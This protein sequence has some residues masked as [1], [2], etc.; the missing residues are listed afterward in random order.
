MAVTNDIALITFV[1][2]TFI[3]L[4]LIGSEA[5]DRLLVP[6]VVLQTIAANLGSMLTPIGNPQNLYL[7]GKAGLSLGSFLLLMLPYALV[8]LL[9]IMLWSTVLTRKD[10]ASIA[11]SF[12]EEIQLLGQGPQLT[13][14]FLLFVLDLLTV[15]RIVPYGLTTIITVVY[16]I[17]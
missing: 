17:K 13:V 16:F 12:T 3:V 1:P 11:V 9:L 6:V 7:Y 5:R 4:R 2:F 8:S 14:Y 10:N 15:A